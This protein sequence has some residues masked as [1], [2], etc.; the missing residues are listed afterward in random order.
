MEEERDISASRVTIAWRL[1]GDCLWEVLHH[2]FFPL[3]LFSLS[4]PKSFNCFCFSYSLQCL[5]G[6]VN[7]KGS[8]VGAWL[9][10]GAKP[11]SPA[12]TCLQ[13]GGDPLHHWLLLMCS[14]CAGHLPAVNTDKNLM[15]L[16]EFGSESE[17][18]SQNDMNKLRSNWDI[19][20][21]ICR[22]LQG[23]CVPCSIYILNT[24][25]FSN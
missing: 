22:A 16:P 5:S 2:F 21:S 10:A 24:V 3:Q 14:F 1:E 12:T 8:C 25:I 15:S 18:Q 9:L 6:S 11:P 23:L 19:K 20:N 17:D 7:W 13:C 4:W